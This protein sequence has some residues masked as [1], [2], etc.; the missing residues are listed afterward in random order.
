MR[1]IYAYENRPT[2]YYQCFKD[3]KRTYEKAPRIVYMKII[4]SETENR[5]VFS[6]K[7]K[8]V[9]AHCNKLQFRLDRTR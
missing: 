4:K 1:G 3:V 8:H 9:G 2:K 7:Y 6:R 5:E